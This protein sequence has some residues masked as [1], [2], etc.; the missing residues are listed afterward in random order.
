VAQIAGPT[1][2]RSLPL[3]GS[4]TGY[5]FVRENPKLNENRPKYF[6]I[7]VSNFGVFEQL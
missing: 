4:K 3:C 6:L 5:G 2:T 7:G 1:F